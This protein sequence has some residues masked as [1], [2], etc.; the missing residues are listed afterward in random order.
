MNRVIEEVVGPRLDSQ[1]TLLATSSAEPLP[2]SRTD[3]LYL[4]DEY[5]NELLDFAAAM[6]P[7]GHNPEQI[8]SVVADHM[9][10]YGF[11]APQGQH[12][13]RWVVSY[14]EA[15]SA[16]FSGPE[17]TRMVVFTEG[18]R[19]A[20][21]V[22]LAC[23]AGSLPVLVV[24]TGNHSWL[25]GMQVTPDSWNHVEWNNYGAVLLSTV[26]ADN[27]PLASARE[28]IMGARTAGVPVIVDESR[29]GFGRTGTLWSQE[30]VGL[31]ADLTV[32]GGPAGGG[33]PLG[34]VVGKTGYL[35]NVGSV[36]PQ[37][38]HPWACAA[39]QAVFTAIHPGVLDHVIESTAALEK[40]LTELVGQFPRR[41]DGF[42][43]PG[44]LKGLRFLDEAQAQEFPVAARAFGLHLAPAVG[45]TVM[46]SPVLVSSTYEVTR[47]VDIMADVLMSWEDG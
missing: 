21:R 20:V 28:W 34:V 25:G 44:L 15:L 16:S 37:S 32:L 9:R 1:R 12:L 22:A 27:R 43:G 2:V 11:T 19:E 24:D 18:E 30:H 33:L 23:A 35:T 31:V 26:H 8:K 41:L 4:W 46:L 10:Y 5:H 38:G 3:L 36:S 7:I 40:A 13:L 6:N 17:D 39:G 29:T 42:H 47:G 14:A 45:N